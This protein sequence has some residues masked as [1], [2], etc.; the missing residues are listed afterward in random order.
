MRY[1]ATVPLGIEEVAAE[2]VRELGASSVTPDVGKVFY[3]GD[4]RLMYLSNFMLRTVNRVFVLLLRERF[5]DLADIGRLAKSL[6]YSEFINKDL[7]F[8]V[9]AERHG[10]HDFTSLDVKR[11]VGA[12]IIESYMEEK[13]HR[14]K[15]NL[16]EPDV[17][18]F[19]LVRDDEVIIGVNTS[20]NSLHKRNYRVFNHPAALKT[21][22]AAA[23]VKL[24]RLGSSDALLDPMCGGATI[25]IEAVHRLRRYPLIM[26]RS[27]FAFRK[28]PIHDEYLEAEVAEEVLEG[29]L[30]DSFRVTGID[31]SPKSLEGAK[32]N[33]RSGFVDDIVRLL[34]GDAA[35]A[36]TYE[37]V[38]AS[39]II[40]NPP[41][42]M[43]S[44]NI[45]KI[46]SFYRDFLKVV[47]DLYPG[48]TLVAITASH[49]AFE[50]A[51]NAVSASIIRKL[52]VMHGGLNAVVFVAR[53]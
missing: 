14:L 4:L 22:L 37:G 45:K 43:R 9:R 46:P 30:F 33:L 8:A 17:E 19:V 49:K 47:S 5:K 24:S 3:E 13:G 50:D 40:T 10:E 32:K 31:I 28:L 38:E 23:M 21:T 44:H 26:F 29:V 51:L 15:V 11:V 12:A 41:Y 18:F 34:W 6:T 52:S 1:F 2:E 25:L 36:E 27:E 16:D 42:G 20:G 35:R 39:V 48:A 7:S 53:V